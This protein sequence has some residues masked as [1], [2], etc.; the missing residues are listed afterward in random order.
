MYTQCPECLTIYK[1]A[2]ELLAQG[3]GSARCGHCAAT[4]D[5][6]RTL[7]EALPEEP[8]EELP[9]AAV[10]DIPPQLSVPALRPQGQPQTLLFNPDERMRRPQSQPRPATPAFARRSSNGHRAVR[11]W[12]WRW[13]RASLA[14]ACL[15]KSPMP[16]ARRCS[17]TRACGRGSTWHARILAAACRCATNRRTLRC[18][19]ATSARIH[20]S[21]TR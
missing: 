5:V 16:S 9:L 21:P 8:F 19:R 20:R 11:A 17:M 3:R 15:R 7:T 14:C 2:A 13:A 4:F 12:P 1:V 6:L 18:F 10:G